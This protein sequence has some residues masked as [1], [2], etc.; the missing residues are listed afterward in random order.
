[1]LKMQYLQDSKQAT[2]VCV[3]HDTV[4]SSMMSWWRHRWCRDDVIGPSLS[5]SIA[6]TERRG[7]VQAAG[8]Q[9][10]EPGSR[11]GHTPQT[12]LRSHFTLRW[13]ASKAT[14][15]DHFVNQ[16]Y[17]SLIFRFCYQN[18]LSQ[19]PL[20]VRPHVKTYDKFGLVQRD[21]NNFFRSA[22]KEVCAVLCW[23]VCN[24]LLG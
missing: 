16:R 10:G 17:C 4:T 9:G 18:S 6:G 7:V 21:L 5:S 20:W 13:K 24:S 23:T 14:C 1:M 15:W 2:N 11:E 8:F 3:T 22:A 12:R 19:L